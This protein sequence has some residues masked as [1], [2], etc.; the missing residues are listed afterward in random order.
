M[1][2]MQHGG[3]ILTA[4]RVFDDAEV[5]SFAAGRRKKRKL[6]SDVQPGTGSATQSDGG[7]VTDGDVGT[8]TE[9]EAAVVKPSDP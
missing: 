4:T 3:F 2:G 1:A 7:Q 8:V 6:E 9:A 5:I